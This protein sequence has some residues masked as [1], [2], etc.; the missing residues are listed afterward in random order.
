LNR[1]QL[2]KTLAPGF[3]PLIV[4]IGAD[5]LWGSRVGLAV[6]VLSGIIELAVAYFREKMLD[7]FVLFDT[8]LI[9]LLGSVS[10]L[11]KTDVFFRLK[12]ALVELIFCVILGISVYSPVNII[13]LMSRRYLKNIVLTREQMLPM[14]R[15]MKTMFYIF[16]GHTVL[17]V[18]A[19]L[20][21]S[22][23][24]WGFISGGL[25][26]LL[27]AAYFLLEWV[28]GRLKRCT[29]HPPTLADK[30]CQSR[31]GIVQFRC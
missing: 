10:I 20:A 9:V 30:V 29:N 7:R 18:Y 1:L 23:Q 8:A 24:A 14:L 3:L 13:A 21:M 16:L 5:A 11:M 27:F 28:R 26:Y 6:A 12:P 17:I 31:L 25:F 2:L 4:F 15:G 19:A 22:V